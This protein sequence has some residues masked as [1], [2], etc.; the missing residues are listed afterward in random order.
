MSSVG[1]NTG[2][3]NKDL[4][5]WVVEYMTDPSISDPYPMLAELQTTDPVHHSELGTWVFTRYADVDQVARDQRW[6]RFE[7][8]QTEMGLLEDTDDDLAIALRAQQMMLINRDE[9]DHTRIRRLLQKTFTPKGLAGWMPRIQQII[10][11]VIDSVVDLDTFDFVSK[12]GYPIPEMVICEL[13]GVPHSDHD[14]WGA[15]ASKSVARNRVNS[16]T[17]ENLREAQ[18]AVLNFNHYFRDLVARRR[19]NPGND[20]VT[21]LIRAEEEGDRLSEDELIG[22]LVMLIT[23]GHETTANMLGNGLYCLLRHPEQYELLIAQPSLVSTAVEE[24]L[25]Y[26]PTPKL[27]LPR[28]STEPIQV[29]EI[30]IPVGSRAIMLRNAANRDPSVFDDPTSFDITRVENRHVSFGTGIHFCLGSV[31]ARTELRMT[32]AALCRRFPQFELVEIPSWR[33]TGVRALN[34]LMVRRPAHSDATESSGHQR[35]KVIE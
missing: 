11:S 15:W 9:P 2:V 18:Q 20:L 24:M 4:A 13:M 34:S 28:L 31:L 17:E 26:E 5:R 32:F 21:L 22:T 12:V 30:T 25:R 6:S 14:L 19:Q 27:G 23:A 3:M 8:A 35:R 1:T 7:A 16:G 33:A 10:D 29:G